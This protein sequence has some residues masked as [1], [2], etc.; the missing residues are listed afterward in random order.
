LWPFT[1]TQ[2]LGPFIDMNHHSIR[3]GDIDQSLVQLHREQ[4]LSRLN[5]LSGSS[6]ATTC[7]LIPAIRDMLSHNVVFPQGPLDKELG[8]KVRGVLLNEGD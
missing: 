8:L 1:N 3:T 4:I 2:Q 7:I 5:S 6:P